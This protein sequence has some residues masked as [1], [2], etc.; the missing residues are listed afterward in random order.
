MRPR[1][2]KLSRRWHVQHVIYG[3][4]GK[5]VSFKHF[6]DWERVTHGT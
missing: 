5:R 6:G 2:A 4:R 1:R 3:T